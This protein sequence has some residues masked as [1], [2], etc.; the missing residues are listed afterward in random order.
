MY[1]PFWVFSFIVLFCVLFAR[2]C[3]LYDCH[4]MS[5]QLQLTN[6]YYVIPNTQ[7]CAWKW[8]FRGKKIGCTNKSNKMNSKTVLAYCNYINFIIILYLVLSFIEI[9]QKFCN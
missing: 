8:F 2:K 4:R 6:I 7:M 5:T 1:V 9:I 3:V